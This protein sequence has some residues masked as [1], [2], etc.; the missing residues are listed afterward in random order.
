MKNWLFC[1]TKNISLGMLTLAF[2][3]HSI[4]QSPNTIIWNKLRDI[5]NDTI[6]SF[7]QKLQQVLQLKGVFEKQKLGQDSVYARILH[8]IGSLEFFVNNRIATTNSILFTHA[9]I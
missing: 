8:R 1:Y 9:A 4:G 5:E 6:L 2:C 7:D 3:F